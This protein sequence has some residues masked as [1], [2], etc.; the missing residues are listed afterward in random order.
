M[1]LFCVG[2]LETLVFDSRGWGHFTA[3]SGQKGFYSPY[4]F[5]NLYQW[6]T[7]ILMLKSR[8]KS[9]RFLGFCADLKEWTLVLMLQ[10]RVW[11]LGS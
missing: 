3:I 10:G 7:V 4:F 1:H 2:L 5:G 8:V 6:W 9:L 11:G